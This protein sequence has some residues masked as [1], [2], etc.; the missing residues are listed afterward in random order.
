MISQKRLGKGIIYLKIKFTQPNTIS[1]FFRYFFYTNKT[2]A[3][4]LLRVFKTA[5]IIFINYYNRHIRQWQKI[6]KKGEKTI[7]G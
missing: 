6:I 7:V 5:N 1:A 2:F 3:N 4:N